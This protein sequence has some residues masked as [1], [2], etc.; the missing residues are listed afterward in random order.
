[1][2]K[3]RPG[4][5]VILCQRPQRRNKRDKEDNYAASVHSGWHWGVKAGDFVAVVDGDI[6]FESLDQWGL[7]NSK[8]P[9]DAY[10]GSQ[11]LPDAW[12]QGT[13][14][15]QDICYICIY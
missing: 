1:M 7:Q 13:L 4:A 3:T 9:S 15:A 12:S 14:C 11:G 10:G 6:S 2:I 5:A 8:Q